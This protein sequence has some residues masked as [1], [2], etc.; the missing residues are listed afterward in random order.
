MEFVVLGTTPHGTY[1]LEASG[2]HQPI[3]KPTAA[4]LGKEKVG[5][6]SETIASISR[7]YYLLKP[8]PGTEPRKIVGKKITTKTAKNAKTQ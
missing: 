1:L 5:T 8:S 3:S 2:E 7:P 4:F 6:I